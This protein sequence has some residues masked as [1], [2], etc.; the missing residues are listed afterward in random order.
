MSRCTKKSSLLRCQACFPC[1]YCTQGQQEPANRRMYRRLHS[2][3]VASS[4]LTNFLSKNRLLR[5]YSISSLISQD[6]ITISASHQHSTWQRSSR[7]YHAVKCSL[8]LSPK[9][10]CL[11]PPIEAIQP[12]GYLLQSR[13]TGIDC[14]AFRFADRSR[15]AIP[16]FCKPSCFLTQFIIRFNKNFI[17]DWFLFKISFRNNNFDLQKL[18][19]YSTKYSSFSS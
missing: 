5:L 4:R 10:E 8:N 7:T 14:L 9:Q 2:F 1:N 13:S 6:D 17:F 18:V 11:E 12:L 16:L 3:F 15:I 19:Y